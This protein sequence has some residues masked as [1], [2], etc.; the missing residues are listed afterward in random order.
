MARETKWRNGSDDSF[1]LNAASR[2]RLV[3]LVKDAISFFLRLPQ[4][5]RSYSIIS[6][7]NLYRFRSGFRK[8]RDDYG[9]REKS[10]KNTII[11]NFAQCRISGFRNRIP[12]IKIKRR[13]TTKFSYKQLRKGNMARESSGK[14]SVADNFPQRQLLLGTS[15]E[16]KMCINILS[17]FIILMQIMAL[18]HQRQAQKKTEVQPILRL[19]DVYFLGFQ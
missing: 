17:G 16:L 4:R 2:N 7:S 14:Y 6:Y 1:S 18:C 5:N 15:Y 13:K 19:K 10:D 8:F 12:Y 11:D 9:T 3:P